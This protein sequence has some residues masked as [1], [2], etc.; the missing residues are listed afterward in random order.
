[1]NEAARDL[2]LESTALQIRKIGNSVGVILPKELLARLKDVY[3]RQLYYYLSRI[4]ALSP[5]PINA[6]LKFAVPPSS[7]TRCRSD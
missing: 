3:K 6:L 4:G 7:R 2:K 1:M 5:M